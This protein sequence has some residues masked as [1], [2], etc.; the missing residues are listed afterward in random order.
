ML[1]SSFGPVATSRNGLTCGTQ[2]PRVTHRHVSQ[3]HVSHRHVSPRAVGSPAAHNRHV[4]HRHVS[5]RHVSHRHV[6][7]RVDADVDGVRAL[8]SRATSASISGRSQVDLNRSRATSASISGRSRVDLNRSRATSASSVNHRGFRALVTITS[9][10][11]RQSSPTKSRIW[12]SMYLPYKEVAPE[13]RCTCHIRKAHLR[14]D[15]PA[16]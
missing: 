6:S 10:R 3:R 5:E 7:Q 9:K 15:V 14:L 2:S 12:G 8:T 16:M 11:V 13:A 4:S 1:P